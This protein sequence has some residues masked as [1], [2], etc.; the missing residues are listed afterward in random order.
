MTRLA[1]GE[2]EFRRPDGR[3]LAEAPRLPEVPI[4]AADVLCE[5]N[6]NAGARLDAQTLTP[7]WDGTRFNVGYAIDVMHPRAN[8]GDRA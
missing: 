6:V 1:S 2:L 4:D 7:N 5:Q 8:G 3:L